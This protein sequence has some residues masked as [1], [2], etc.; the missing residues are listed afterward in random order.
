MSTL[1]SRCGRT[2]LARMSKS[3]CLMVDRRLASVFR[4]LHIRLD[5]TQDVLVFQRLRVAV[6][7]EIPRLRDAKVFAGPRAIFGTQDLQDFLLRPAV[8]LALVPLAVRVLGGV[9]APVLVRHVAQDVADDVPRGIVETRVSAGQPGIQIEL[10]ELRVVIK[11][12]LEVRDEPFV[13]HGVNGKSR[14][15]SGHTSPPRPSC[16]RYERLCPARTGRPCARRPGAGER[17][18][19]AGGISGPC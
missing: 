16:G 19:A 8:E 7:H 14:R 13:I 11:H 5:H 6:V 15:R 12:F 9:E 18:P 4:E 1:S 10:D 3:F 2:R 17:A